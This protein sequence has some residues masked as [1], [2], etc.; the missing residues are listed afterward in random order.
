MQISQEYSE[1]FGKL[2]E[3]FA[4]IGDA[5]PRFRAYEMLFPNHEGLRQALCN[6]Y[7]NILTF[8]IDAKSIFLRAR[9]SSSMCSF[10]VT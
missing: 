2:V 5:L 7:L 4:R 1:Y 10:L 3:M 9:K 8:C 6:A